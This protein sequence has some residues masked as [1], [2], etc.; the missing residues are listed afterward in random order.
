[1][2]SQIDHLLTAF[3]SRFS[4]K[5]VL[6]RSPGR[7]NLIG[8]HTDYN[9]GFVLPAAIDQS[10]F[11]AIYPNK[12][13]KIRAV[14]LDMDHEHFEAD[15]SDTV[16]KSK[17]GWANY[18]L[19]VIHLFN[20]KKVPVPGFDCVFGGTIPIGAG[21]SSSAALEGAV[22]FG[23]DHLLGLN[24][25]R[26]EMAKLGQQ[27]E[28]QFVG[29][30]CGIMD[31]FAN[32]YGK[33]KHAIRLDCKNLKHQLIPF[34][35]QEVSLL[36]CDTNVHRELAGSEY[37][38]RRKQCEEA[39]TY[40]A[41]LDPNVK[42]LRDLSGE[43]LEENRKKLSPIVYNRS[44]FVLD[45]NDRVLKGTIDLQ[46]GDLQSFGIR[47]YESHQGLRDLYEVSCSELDILVEA[48]KN[49]PGVIGSR[50][51]GGGFGGCTINLVKKEFAAE[52]AGR[53]SLIYKQK[54]NQVLSTYIVQTSDGT[55]L[56]T[57]E[58]HVEYD[59]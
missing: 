36:L 45:E 33:E 21:L 19:G 34:P 37:N 48:A 13:N 55:N 7:A 12:L 4:S 14:A 44:R 50:M 49:L 40:F 15:I 6:V 58:D 18:L 17:T 53:L 57:V 42:S 51:M 11:M 3:K 25:S 27:V 54:C 39:V 10:I 23:L 22:I 41:N 28:H 38:V 16:V 26:L 46:E 31:Q 29:V 20:Q 52:I 1:M 59:K 9:N 32:L 56:M 30:N 2:Q 8:D 5:P 35:D 47:M 43:L 24:L